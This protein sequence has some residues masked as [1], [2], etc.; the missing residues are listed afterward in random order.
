MT[1]AE[2]SLEGRRIVGY[3]E[4]AVRCVPL[5]LMCL[6]GVFWCTGAPESGLLPRSGSAA[7]VLRTAVRT[8]GTAL[9][10]SCLL[11]R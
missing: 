3:R 1:P 2:S 11:I 9:T 8:F 7:A 4:R 6:F 5:A 10:Y